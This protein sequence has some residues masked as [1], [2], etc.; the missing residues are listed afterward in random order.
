MFL[1]ARANIATSSSTY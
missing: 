1:L